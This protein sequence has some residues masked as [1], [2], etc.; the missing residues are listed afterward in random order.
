[1]NI[2]G[3]ENFV[4][5]DKAGA[6]QFKKPGRG[7]IACSVEYSHEEVAKIREEAKANGKYVFVK[8]AEWI[9]EAGDVVSVVEKTVYVATKEYYRE[10]K[11]VHAA[12]KE[13]V[14][15]SF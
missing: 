10:R 3:K 13:V 11:R 14:D 6:I 5:W 7:R 2:L 12:V 1:M 8:S 4:V 15:S 9:D